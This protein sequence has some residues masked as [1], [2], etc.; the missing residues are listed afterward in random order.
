MPIYMTIDNLLARASTSAHVG[1][2][3]LA[4][5]DGSVR[6]GHDL[7][8]IAAAVARAH[9]RGLDAIV[10]GQTPQAGWSPVSGFQSQGI[11]A[12]LIGLLL[13][14]VQKVREA[15]RRSEPVDGLTKAALATLQRALK[16][17]GR[18]YVVGADGKLLRGM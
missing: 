4:M 2:L 9:P 10:I 11:I 16:P 12:I 7:P 8:D 5:G 18:I 3:N 6:V 14:A 13:P 17:G 1:G 15:A